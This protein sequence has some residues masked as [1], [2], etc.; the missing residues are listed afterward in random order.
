LEATSRTSRGIVLLPPQLRE[1]HIELGVKLGKFI[2]VRIVIAQSMYSL[3]KRGNVCLV[4]FPFRNGLPVRNLRFRIIGRKR[5]IERSDIS[6]SFGRVP[7]GGKRDIKRKPAADFTLAENQSKSQNKKQNEESFENIL[8]NK[9]G[10]PMTKMLKIEGMMCSHCEMNV[11][12]ALE[13]ID[14]V[15]SAVPSSKAGTAYLTLN[16]DV[17]DETL[18]SAVEAADYKVI[19]IE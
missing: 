1:N 5:F 6:V 2:R 3:Q 17:P 10:N 13:S 15:E 4:E 11:K 19:G 18:K 9:E 14:G 12:K 16:K 7:V 8:I